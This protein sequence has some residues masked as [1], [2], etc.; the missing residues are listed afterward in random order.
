MY[1]IIVTSAPHS[2]I[3]ITTTPRCAE[4]VPEKYGNHHESR[5]A[6]DPVSNE[7]KFGLARVTEAARIGEIVVNVAHKHDC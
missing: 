3:A 2:R 4:A 7:R 1:A 6:V 5:I